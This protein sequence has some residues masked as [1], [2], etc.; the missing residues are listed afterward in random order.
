MSGQSDTMPMFLQFLSEGDKRLNIASTP[1]D[2]NNNVELDLASNKL[3]IGW[4]GGMGY[5]P[6]PPARGSNQAPFYTHQSRDRRRCGRPLS[7]VRTMRYDIIGIGSLAP[8]TSAPSSGMT[9]R[10]ESWSARSSTSLSPG[11]GGN[12]GGGLGGSSGGAM[13][14]VQGTGTVNRGTGGCG[15]GSRRTERGCNRK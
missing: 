4:G 1:N 3:G 14:G 8:W 5:P 13:V 10:R 6:P 11:L 2:L 15:D 12:L 7:V 9:V